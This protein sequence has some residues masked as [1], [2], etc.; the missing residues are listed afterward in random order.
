MYLHKM[1]ILLDHWKRGKSF[2]EGWRVAWWIMQRD[3]MHWSMETYFCM[4]GLSEE[5]SD[6]ILMISTI[7][8]IMLSKQSDRSHFE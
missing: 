8:Y 4:E 2:Y 5:Y 1:F 7:A 3:A 6:L